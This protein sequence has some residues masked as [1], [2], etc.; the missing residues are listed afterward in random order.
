MNAVNED[1]WMLLGE[2]YGFIGNSLL[3][4]MNQT[5]PIG[6][7]PA[8]WG[9][10]PTAFSG[11][12]V[13]GGLAKLRAYAADAQ[14]LGDEKAVERAA[15]EY[16]RLFIGP[17]APVAPPWET[18]NRADGATVGFGEATFQM[19]RLLREAALEMKNENNQYEDHIGIELL[20]L[21]ELC[22]RCAGG[23]SG[24]DAEGKI[25]CFIDEHPLSWIEALREKVDA[26]YPRGYITGLLE[27][28]EGVLLWQREA[29]GL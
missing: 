27:L 16:T 13:A 9:D 8:F 21:S 22:R 29:L 15:V 26:E 17:P 1:T 4:P 25:A 6:L 12:H 23:E 5:P 11:E 10:F 20:Y 3:K 18:M 24:H 19:R 2:T 28:A 7:D 14:A